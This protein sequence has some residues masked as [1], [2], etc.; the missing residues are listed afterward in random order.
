MKIFFNHLVLNAFSSK[1]DEKAS[2]KLQIFSIIDRI[3][4]IW[5]NLTSKYI[6]KPPI[7]PLSPHS[8][9]KIPWN[10]I[11]QIANFKIP[12]K[13]TQISTPRQK[14]WTRKNRLSINSTENYYFLYN[15]I[16]EIHSINFVWLGKNVSTRYWML[17]EC[18]IE[19]L[20]DIG[21]YEE[22]EI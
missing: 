18:V 1:N 6:K 9:T 14:K 12:S 20:F 4:Q 11:C 17:D 2:P 5:C 22:K 7:L 19:F 21:L 15:S 13:R 8:Q 10:I 16:F 3:D